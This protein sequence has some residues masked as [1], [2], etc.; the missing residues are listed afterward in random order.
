MTSQRPGI[1][2]SFTATS[3]QTSL[4]PD[5]SVISDN[6]DSDVGETSISPLLASQFK[7]K[8]RTS[9]IWDHTPYSRIIGRNALRFLFLT[10]Y[11]LVFSPHISPI[12]THCVSRIALMKSENL[13]H[14]T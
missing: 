14:E 12:E 9:K 7:K 10:N 6:G 13:K 1:S 3:S 11:R 2:V 5:S 4:A 8:K